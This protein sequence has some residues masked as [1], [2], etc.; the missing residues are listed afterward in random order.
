MSTL[1]IKPAMEF[2]DLISKTTE[3]LGHIKK[4]KIFV[5]QIESQYLQLA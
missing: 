5:A 4:L 2:M 1:T 3:Y